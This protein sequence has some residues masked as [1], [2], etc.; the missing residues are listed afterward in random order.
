M[1][2]CDIIKI[3]ADFPL[4][5]RG[6][7]CECNFDD[8]GKAEGLADGTQADAG[9]VGTANRY[10]KIRL[11]NYEC[12][13]FKDT[14]HT[15]IVTLA[16]F[17]G[18]ST[19]YLLGLTETKN[20][21][22]AELNDLHLSDEMITLLKGENINTRLLCEMV[23]H[24]DFVKLLSDIEIYVDSIASMQVKNLNALADMARIEIMEK[25][26]PGEND[27]NI[28]LL[29]ATHIEEDM[30][31]CQMV[32]RDIDSIIQDIRQ[33]HK[34][35]STSA[36]DFSAVDEI[37]RSIE[38]VARFQGSDEEKRVVVLLH[39]LGIDYHK[40]TPVEFQTMIKIL[41]RSKHMVIPRKRHRKNRH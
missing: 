20:H 30:Y 27:P 10:F 28:R 13:D 9:T 40:L 19:D 12:D 34:G 31:F 22:N 35:T 17:Y 15:S 21:P 3:K 4:E 38:E 11:G 18:V 33:A 6:C 7:G 26:H 32:H 23:A 25:Y 8:T 16:K 41:E 5:R 37:K 29:N 36:P 14:S 24:K 39:H 2:I 1:E